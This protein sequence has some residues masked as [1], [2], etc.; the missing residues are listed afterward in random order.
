MPGPIQAAQEALTS[1]VEHPTAQAVGG[2]IAN[3]TQ[4]PAGG[5]ALFGGTQFASATVSNQTVGDPMITLL[6]GTT[7]VGIQILKEHFSWFKP[8]HIWP[9]TLIIAGVLGLL[10]WH[11]LWKAVGGSGFIAILSAMNYKVLE[12][13][14]L[15]KS[16]TEVGK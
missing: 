7:T 8:E 14:K 1:A 12:P 5:V 3:V 11:D 13:T 15:M 9:A 6:A 4:T 10:W 2:T 16:F